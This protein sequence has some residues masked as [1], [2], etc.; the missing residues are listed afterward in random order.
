[1]CMQGG[2]TTPRQSI[3]SLSNGCTA[4]WPIGMSITTTAV[5]SPTDQ[6]LLLLRES[7]FT[8]P[9]SCTVFCGT[10]NV[11]AK[12]QEGGLHDWILPSN[13]QYAD[14]YAIGFQEIVDLNA[15]NVAIN[16]SN[17][18]QRA[19]F[20]QEKIAECLLLTKAKYTLIQ[21]KT[22]VGL[23]L[24]VYVKD[25]L[26]SHVMDVRSTQLGVGLMGMM[27]NK[28]GVSVRLCFY[29]SSIC[30]VCAHLAAHRENI[31]GRN[32]DYRSIIDRSYFIADPSNLLKDASSGGYEGDIIDAIDMPKRSGEQL[33]TEDLNI[34]QH[35]IIF[36]LGDLNYRI[37]DVL[38]VKEV[39]AAIAAKQLEELSAKDQLNIERSKGNVFH[40]FDEGICACGML[41]TVSVVRLDPTSCRHCRPTD[42]RSH[43][44]VPAWDGRV[45][46]PPGQED[47]GPRVVRPG[48]V[49]D[50][51]RLAARAAAGLQVRAA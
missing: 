35:E 14:I 4:I 39:F 10:W 30:F 33:L 6:I 38:T 15:M 28:G 18:I 25:S 47:P 17:T 37:D 42:L 19:Q 44:Q 49:E 36:W 29:D 32:S 7:E 1:M 24:C 31:I 23:L 2:A 11:N 9:T 45:R 43:V 8:K 22:L 50:P 48:A 34:H 51:S 3:A 40:G 27:G 5:S 12:K 20:W 16:S 41:F 26:L 21:S 46:H 13:Q